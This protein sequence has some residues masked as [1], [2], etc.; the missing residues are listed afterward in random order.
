KG[1]LDAG[2][3][4]ELIQKFEEAMND[5]FNTAQ[6]I[7]YLNTEL[8]HLNSMR[9]KSSEFLTGVSSIKKIGDV[10]G[11]FSQNPA[12]YFEREK[13]EGLASIGISEDEIK[14]LISEREMARKEKRWKDGDRIRDELNQKGIILED[15]PQGTKWKIK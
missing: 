7:G 2:V 4:N 13:S 6:V 15:S 3:D 14:R 10:L 1:K 11:L 8:H 5:D 12:G 9:S